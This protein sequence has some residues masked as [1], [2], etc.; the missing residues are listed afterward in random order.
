MKKLL[1]VMLA[2]FLVFTVISFAVSAEDV[3]FVTK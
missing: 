3:L 2:T 1:N